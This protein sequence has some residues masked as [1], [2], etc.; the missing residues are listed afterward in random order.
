MLHDFFFALQETFIMVTASGIISIFLGLFLSIIMAAQFYNPSHKSASKSFIQGLIKNFIEFYTFIPFMALMILFL[1]F[2]KRI[3]HLNNLSSTIICLVLAT[4]P[5]YVALIYSHLNKLPKDLHD[6]AKFYGINKIKAITL[7]YIPECTQKIIQATTQMFLHLV[8]YS[9]I[10]GLLGAPGLGK[11][12]VEYGYNTFNP[13]YLLL[14]VGALIILS[15]IIV[16]S[17][18]LFHRHSSIST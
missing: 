4:T 18:N 6:I 13:K 16:L 15:K 9:A 11:L 14:A 3:P 10:A 2:I 5:L 17:G 7:I 8:S 1:P 12:I